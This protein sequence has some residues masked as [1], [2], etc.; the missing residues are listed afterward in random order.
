MLVV[1][2]SSQSGTSTSES[3]QSGHDLSVGLL[4]EDCGIGGTVPLLEPQKAWPLRATANPICQ[5]K[6]KGNEVELQRR[7]EL[8]F[9]PRDRMLKYFTHSVASWPDN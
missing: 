6:W 8:E 9:G 5:V 2:L 1:R 3:N 7:V 4:K